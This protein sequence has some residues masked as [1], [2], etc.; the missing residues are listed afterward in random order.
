[1]AALTDLTPTASERLPDF[2]A[3]PVVEIVGSVQFIPLP[4]LVLRDMIDVGARFEGYQLNELQ[5]QLHAIQELP[6]GEVASPPFPQ[7]FLGQQPQRALYVTED[8]RFIAQLQQDRIAINERRTDPDRAPS[9][10]HVWPQLDR[11]A[12]A[13]RDVLVRGEGFGPANANVIELTYVNVVR[14]AP[15]DRVLRII[16]GDAGEPP[17]SNAEPPAVRFSFPIFEA[18]RFRGRLHVE[19][20]PGISDGTPVLQLQ[21]TS[22]RLV[23][24]GLPLAEVFDACHRDAVHAFVAVTEPDMH[25]LWR[26][27]R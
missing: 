15:M 16:S 25:R 3:P 26:R 4:R 9:S 22:R 23:E 6:P 12:H 14:D 8:Q 10:L 7:M 2:D 17:Y 18:E 20:G 1:M 11:L 13:V 24:K 27:T 21:L 19:A 5:P